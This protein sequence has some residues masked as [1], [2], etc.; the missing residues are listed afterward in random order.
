VVQSALRPGL[1][2]TLLGVASARVTFGVWHL[3]GVGIN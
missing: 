1:R 2:Q 3:I